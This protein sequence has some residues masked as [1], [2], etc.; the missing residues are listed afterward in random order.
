METDSW[1]DGWMEAALV[2]QRLKQAKGDREQKEEKSSSPEPLLGVKWLKIKQSVQMSLMGKVLSKGRL[3]IRQN[4]KR[5]STH[6][7]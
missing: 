5:L 6:P 3:R 7:I 4:W 1:A 2:A